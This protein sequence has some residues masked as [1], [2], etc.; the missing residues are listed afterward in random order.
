MSGKCGPVHTRAR[1]GRRRARAA[2]LSAPPP[3]RFLTGKRVICPARRRSDP[4]RTTPGGRAAA[5]RRPTWARNAANRP[6]SAAPL[7]EQRRGAGVR[8]VWCRPAQARS[9]WPRRAASENRPGGMSGERAA[10]AVGVPGAPSAK[11]LVRRLPASIG[12]VGTRKHDQFCAGGVREVWCGRGRL[13]PAGFRAIVRAEHL[14]AQSGASAALPALGRASAVHGRWNDGIP[15]RISLPAGARTVARQNPCAVAARAARIRPAGGESS[16]AL[17]KGPWTQVKAT[18]VR[19]FSGWTSGK[20]QLI[21]APR[22][23]VERPSWR[24][25]ARKG[26]PHAEQGQEIVSTSNRHGRAATPRDRRTTAL[27]QRGWWLGP[28]PPRH[29]PV[30]R[31]CGGRTMLAPFDEPGSHATQ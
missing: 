10:S 25:R 18:S 13:D 11:A 29:H 21:I 2:P 23:T 27:S 28:I 30:R 14:V 24:G 6:G 22:P 16:R 5:R 9:T 4:E 3:P 19:N 8:E 17:A 15:P 20:E 26:E 7:H 31:E 12:P 1:G